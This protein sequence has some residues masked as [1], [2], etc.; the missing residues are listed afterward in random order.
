LVKYKPELSVSAYKKLSPEAMIILAPAITS[1]P[2]TPQLKFVEG[3][4]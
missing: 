2:G 1:K 4:A 3:V